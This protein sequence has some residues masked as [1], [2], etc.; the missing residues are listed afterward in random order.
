MDD[1]ERHV[2]HLLRSRFEGSFEQKVQR[3]LEVRPQAIV[4]HHHFTAVS[5]ECIALYREGFFTATAMAT[6][7]LNEGLIRFVA[8]RNKMPSNQDPHALVD[9][10]ETQKIISPDGIA[11][12]RRVLRS[13]RNDFHH[14]NPSISKVPVQDIAKRNIEDIAAIEREL[15]DHE[16]NEGRIKPKQPQYW[17]IS[18]EG[19]MLVNLRSG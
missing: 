15:F 1:Y 11:A 12:F 16:V 3:A 13:F 17:D 9:Q 6:Q 8:E 2:R 4:P 10:F 18:A 5:T 19:T 14:L 7:A